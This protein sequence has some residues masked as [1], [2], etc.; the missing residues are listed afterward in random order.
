[1]KTIKYNMPSLLSSIFCL[2]LFG[3]VVDIQAAATWR[4][5]RPMS[6]ARVY[7]TSTL[8]NNGNLLVVGGKTT[9]ACWLV[10]SYFILKL[11][12]GPLPEL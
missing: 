5:S 7:A 9:V 4:L 10:L 6:N 12:L 8:L 3:S 11:V 2:A 1:M